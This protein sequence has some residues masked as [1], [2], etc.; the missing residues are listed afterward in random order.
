MQDALLTRSLRYT[1]L[2]VISVMSLGS[3]ILSYNAI[4]DLLST[5]YRVAGMKL[6]WGLGAGT[7]ALLLIRFRGDLIEI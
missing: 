6:A 1:I 3:L 4:F 5:D 2:A 7:A